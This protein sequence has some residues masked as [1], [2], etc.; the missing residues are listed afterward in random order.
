V[1]RAYS[2]YLWSRKNGLESLSFEQAVVLEGQRPDPMPPDKSYARPFDYLTRG[3]Y[4][5]FAANYYEMFGRDR[6]RFF[7]YEDITRRPQALLQEI[8][9]F[10]DVEPRTLDVRESELF[11]AARGTGPPLDSA[12]RQRLRRSVRPSVLRFAEISGLD[13]SPWGYVV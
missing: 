6:V 1:E 5:R 8:Q 13:I 3:D 9:L 10:L 7:L 11:N 12:V 2:N 4:A